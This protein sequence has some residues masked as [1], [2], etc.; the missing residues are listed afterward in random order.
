MWYCPYKN[1]SAFSIEKALTPAG[2][3]LSPAAE[4]LV[5]RR[6]KHSGYCRSVKSIV[7]SPYGFSTRMLDSQQIVIDLVRHRNGLRILHSP[8]GVSELS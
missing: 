5:L 2:L 7:L 1:T 3:P 4:G 8:D 6:Q